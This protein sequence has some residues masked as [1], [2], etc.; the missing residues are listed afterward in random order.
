MK[1]PSPATAIALVALFFSLGGVGLAASHYLI[2]STSQIKPSVLK[3]LRGAQGLAGPQ[4][5]QGLQGLQGPAGA[6][7]AAGAAGTA[8]TP[9][10]AGTAHAWA[11]VASD[12]TLIADKNVSS[13]QHTTNSGIYCLT[14]AAGS[15]ANTAAAVVS[16]NDDSDIGSY[17]F[18][19]K[20]ASDCSSG[21]AEVDTGLLTIGSATTNGSAL[22][23]V[24]EDGGFTVLFP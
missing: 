14:L 19:T 21:Q 4:G 17:V 15:G 9:G 6:A 5:L 12:G 23:G 22:A 3:D 24:A 1:R 16:M 13:V 10:A 7:G 18:I 2:T 8:G 11:V 20:S